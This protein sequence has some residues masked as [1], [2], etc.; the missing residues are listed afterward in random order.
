MHCGRPRC[1]N[2]TEKQCCHYNRL[3]SW[4][5]LDGWGLRWRKTRSRLCGLL[6]QRYLQYNN[7]AGKFNFKELHCARVD[8]WQHLL[9][10]GN[11]EKC[12]KLQSIIGSIINSRCKP[13]RFPNKPSRQSS[14]NNW[15]I[16]WSD[17]VCWVIQWRLSRDW[18]QNYLKRLSAGCWCNKFVLYLKGTLIGLNL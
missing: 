12:H 7:L 6:R 14:F 15:H 4:D 16:D 13:S 2:L 1:A 5:H 3:T 17:L 11:I 18:L 10:L 9:I 8:Y